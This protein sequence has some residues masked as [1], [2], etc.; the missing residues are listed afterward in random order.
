MH[1]QL[2]DVDVPP[3]VGGELR[4]VGAG[5]RLGR[6]GRG[7]SSSGR[8]SRSRRR[9]QQQGG[10]HADVGGNDHRPTIAEDDAG[11]GPDAHPRLRASAT[12]S[13]SPSGAPVQVRG[14]AG[15][16][17]ARRPGSGSWPPGTG[18]VRIATTMKYTGAGPPA[19]GWCSPPTV[20]SSPT[21]TSSRAPPRSRSRVMS[22][23]RRTPPRWSARHQGRRRRPAADG[24]SGLDRRRPDDSVDP[25]VSTRSPR[26]ATPRARATSPPRAAGAGAR[27][28]D[29]HPD[30]GQRRRASGSPA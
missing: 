3:V 8:R 18:L 16:P 1:G 17:G 4:A 5:D 26:S 30:R 29:H 25:A 11:P 22:T 28:V 10:D 7:R 9:D 13:A 14:R 12:P 2:R 27:P 20:R 23:G 15:T 24:A 21:T 19:P 6:T